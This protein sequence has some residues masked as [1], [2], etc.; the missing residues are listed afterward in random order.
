MNSTTDRT[1]ENQGFNGL[2]VAAFES[3][4]SKEMEDLISRHGGLP[5]VAPSMR[6][7]PLSENKPAF[8]FFDRLQHGEVDVI[9][10]MTGVGT[11]ILFDALESQAAPSRIQKAFKN[12]VL[13]PRGPKPVKALADRKMRPSVVVPEPNTWKEVLETLDREHPVKGLTVAVQEY[14]ISN[15]EFIKG[16]KARGAK[17]VY[18]V[19]VYQW[20]LPEDAR[21]LIHLI[22]TIVKG[23]VA[24]A[25]FTSAT[26]VQNVFQVAKGIGLE[27]RLK[28]AFSRV[29]VASIGSVCSEALKE[30]GMAADL[31]PEHPKMGFLVKEA[32]EKS[33][34]IG[35]KKALHSIKTSPAPSRPEAKT[36]ANGD[37][38]VAASAKSEAKAPGPPWKDSLFLKACRCEP[39]PRTP[40]WIMRQ[41]GRYLPEYRQVRAK[42]SF[43]E[44][45]KTPEL[46]AEVTVTAQ[47]ALGVDAAILF[48]DI[49][50][51]AEPLG[52]HLEYLE[53]GGP[54]IHNPFRSGADLA[55]LEQ[56]EA[57]FDLSY[58][59]QAIRLIR[60]ELKPHIPLIGFAGAPFTLAS[61][62]IE[63]GGSKDYFHTRSVMADIQ[64]WDLMMRRLVSSTVSYLNA[65]INAGVQ[66]VQLFDS[67]V[68]ILAPE[69]F[70]RL[71]L[72][73]LKTLI[74]SLKPGVP[75]IY[76][77]TQTAPFY[78][79]LKETGATVVGVDWRVELDKAWKQ[80]GPVAIQ[81]NLNPDILLTDTATVCRETEKILRLAGGKPGHIFNL[82]HGI[83][84]QTP[85]DNVRAMIET[86][87]N[88]K[89][90]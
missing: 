27:D 41:A 28:E 54:K 82:G 90:Q 68:G 52:F 87:K 65:Q 73:Y 51:I 24:V 14:G 71:V 46:A 60:A 25:L 59:N 69:E 20:A 8:Q 72:P 32:A 85:M 70:Q 37:L 2:T 45:C 86:V 30:H 75:V 84:P 47:Q 23:E 55:R 15:E 62:L 58:V 81:G 7:I 88:W 39:T 89:N 49:L 36:L 31:E 66:A 13:V 53:S 74:G 64:L 1:T 34:E 21:P 5:R 83:L 22:E 19:P 33:L 76:F 9:V 10:F 48:S 57:S 16:L 43:L 18:S 63:G 80:L 17:A 29:V 56:V 38:S 4:M 44:L 12:A 3:R 79:W 77:G 26:Q 67:W 42:V 61:Y 50:V 11:K 6:E 78:P 40:L 35:R